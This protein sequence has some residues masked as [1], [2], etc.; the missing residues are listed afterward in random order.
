MSNLYNIEIDQG[1][2]FILSL[3]IENEVDGCKFD[4]TGWDAEG[5][6]RDTY[7]AATASATFTMVFG[8][9]RSSGSLT[10]QLPASRTR[11]LVPG[12]KFWDLE[13]TSGSIVL[14]IIEGEAKITPEVTK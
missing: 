14:R 12:I 2:T 1:A 7:A 6:I 9:P 11:T 8:T 4:L 5:Q 10:A 13:L 3:D